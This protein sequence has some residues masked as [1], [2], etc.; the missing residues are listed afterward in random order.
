P[1]G[2]DWDQMSGASERALTARMVP[3]SEARHNDPLTLR[4]IDALL[5]ARVLLVTGAE[6]RSLLRIAHDRVL[7]SW[8]RAQKLIEKNRSFYRIRDAVEQARTRWEEG[9]RLP[10][11][12][13]P[14]GAPVTQAKEMLLGYE[15]ELSSDTRNYIRRSMGR[16]EFWRRVTM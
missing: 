6:N 1:V 5:A 16:A 13:L 4:V 14:A 8:K 11:L 2:R 3:L 9:E 15:G 10:E 7:V 12:L